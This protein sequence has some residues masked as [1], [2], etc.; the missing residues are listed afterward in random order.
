MGRIEKLVDRYQ[1]YISL[2]WQKD[3]AG[4]QRAIFI[5]YDKSDER[6]L[7][8][9]I[10]LFGLAT[11]DAGHGWKI[12]D[13]TTAFSTWMSSIDYRDAYFEDPESLEL[14]LEEDF[15]DYVAQ[16]LHDTLT[17]DDVD[18]QTV[19]GVYGLASLFGFARVSEVMARI[20]KSIRGRLVVLFP[21]EYDNNNYRLLDARD[22]WN[23]HAIPIT[24]HQE[25][26]E[27]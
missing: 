19:V 13:L 16:L 20:E 18:D 26:F 5:V 2:P 10:E 8:A 7:R 6:R 22:G 14:K 9:R 23:Y 11:K 4:A 27:S 12:C 1:R 15:L 24:L 17:A 25:L 3:L 21:G